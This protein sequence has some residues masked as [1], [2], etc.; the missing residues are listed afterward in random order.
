MPEEF[1]PAWE[2]WTPDPEINEILTESSEKDTLSSLLR[3]NYSKHDNQNIGFRIGHPNSGKFTYGYEKGQRFSKVIIDRSR[4]PYKRVK[5][6]SI[7]FAPRFCKGCSKTFI[8][9]WERYS[10]YCSPECGRDH[11]NRLV[12]HAKWC[13]QNL[14]EKENCPT[15]NNVVDR[16]TIY[17]KARGKVKKIYCSKRCRKTMQRRVFN[18]KR[19]KER[20][21]CNQLSR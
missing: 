2:Y 10:T 5:K 8:P 17:P 11:Y 21:Q 4:M 16:S 20:E 1:D 3:I 15:C 18:Q 14:E 12:N 6:R 9:N 7:S 13:N 19:K